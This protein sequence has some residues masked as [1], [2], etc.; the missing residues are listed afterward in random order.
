MVII[1]HRLN[2]IAKCDVIYKVE[3]GKITETA[4]WW[5][6]A[7]LYMRRERISI[8]D[9]RNRVYQRPRPGESVV[10]LCYGESGGAGKRLWVRHGGPGAVCSQYT[11]WPG[12]VLYGCGSGAC[13]HRGTEEGFPGLSW[14]GGQ[15]L[16]REF[17]TWSDPW[18]LCGGGGSADPP[19]GR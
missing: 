14:C 11:Q 5:Q 7:E 17:Q 3:N 2:T 15:A 12:H 8:A 4:L 6:T 13:D 16:Y 10:L 1:A 19:G 9:D 18:L